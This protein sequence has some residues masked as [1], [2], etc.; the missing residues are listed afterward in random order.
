MDAHPMRIFVLGLL[1]SATSITGA[2]ASPELDRECQIVVTEVH[3][4]GCTASDD[5]VAAMAGPACASQDG[6]SVAA[7]NPCKSPSDAPEGGSRHYASQADGPRRAAPGSTER[8][9][10]K[11]P[12]MQ[13]QPD[14]ARYSLKGNGPSR[15]VGVPIWKSITVGTITQLSALR[16]ALDAADVHIGDSADEILGRPAFHLSRTISTFDLVIRTASQLGFDSNYVSLDELYKR[17]SQLGFE[18]CP[19][20]IGPML[21]LQYADQPIGEFLHIAML[22]SMTYGRALIS[23]IVANG[24]AGLLLVGGDGRLEQMAPSS[25]AFVFVRPN[26]IALPA[27]Q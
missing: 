19:A 2:S 26:Q 14:R 25:E 23:L 7:S 11:S 6:P 1:L 20:E 8:E 16:D 21:R 4:C 12:L 27:A 15:A 24:G 9:V 5:P 13:E 10:C 22:P 3:D 17:A 18:L